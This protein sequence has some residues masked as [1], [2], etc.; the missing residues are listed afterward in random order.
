MEAIA[1]WILG[2]DGTIALG[3]NYRGLELTNR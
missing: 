1:L 3:M 2:S